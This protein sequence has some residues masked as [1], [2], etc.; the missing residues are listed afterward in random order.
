VSRT[1]F[2]GD[3]DLPREAIP[4]TRTLLVEP[5]RGLRGHAASAEHVIQLVL[6]SFSAGADEN[7]VAGLELL[8][9]GGNPVL[10]LREADGVAAGLLVCVDDDAGPEELLERELFD[11]LR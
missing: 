3:W 10:H 5:L 9:A 4:I 8:A 11:R 7:G 2:H 1:G 6:E